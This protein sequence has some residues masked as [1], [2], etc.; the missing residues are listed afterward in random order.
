MI[1]FKDGSVWT[2]ENHPSG[3]SL[4]EAGAKLKEELKE[5]KRVLNE[6]E[7][8]VDDLYGQTFWGKSRCKDTERLQA[9]RKVLD[10]YEEN[11]AMIQIWDSEFGPKTDHLYINEDDPAFVELARKKQEFL[12]QSLIPRP[13]PEQEL[14]SFRKGEP[15]KGVLEAIFEAEKT[16]KEDS[17]IFQ[18]FIKTSDLSYLFDR[19]PELQNAMDQLRIFKSSE[20]IIEYGTKYVPVQYMA[21]T[22]NEESMGSALNILSEDLKVLGSTNCILGCLSM[23]KILDLINVID[24]PKRFVVYVWPF[25][26]CDKIA[27]SIGKDFYSDFKCSGPDLLR[28]IGIKSVTYE[29]MLGLEIK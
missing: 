28:E 6:D 27:E 13:T 16:A 18:K 21:V 24:G 7:D 19:M 14:A 11:L 17:D 2:E 10:Q 4:V 5:R 1:K 25:V 15:A 9:Y 29:G 22:C 23:P 26:D 8:E 3:E 20:N 12:D